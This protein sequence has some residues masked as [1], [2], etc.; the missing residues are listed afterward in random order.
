MNRSKSLLPVIFAL[1]GFILIIITLFMLFAIFDPFKEPD[2]GGYKIDSHSSIEY[3]I[4]LNKEGDTTFTD[5]YGINFIGR[6]IRYINY[7]DSISEGCA[8]KEA[9]VI[10]P[11]IFPREIVYDSS[12]ILAVQHPIEEFG[13]KY[14]YPEALYKDTTIVNGKKIPIW[15]FVINKVEDIEYGPYTLAQYLEKRKEIG[16]PNNLKLRLE[17]PNILYKFQYKKL[18]YAR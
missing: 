17:D 5:N 4:S 13:D 8:S 9:R 2:L 16:I 3:F 1:I 14:V 10:E 12:F 15:F 7:Y 11:F 18:K 6:K